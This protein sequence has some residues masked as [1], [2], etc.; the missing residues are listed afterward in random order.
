MNENRIFTALIYNK[1]LSVFRLWHL[2]TFRTIDT[3]EVNLAHVSVHVSCILFFFFIVVGDGVVAAILVIF[4]E[5][6]KSL[7]ITYF[8]SCNH[9]TLFSRLTF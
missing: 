3:T 1:A 7:S 5:C 2:E 4:W 8:H 9:M 6:E